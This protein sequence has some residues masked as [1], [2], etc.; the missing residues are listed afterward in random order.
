M[1]RQRAGLVA[2]AMMTLLAQASPAKTPDTWDNLH[3]VKSEKLDAVYLSDGADFRP[4]AKVILDPTHVAFRKNWLRD[5]N[6]SV[7]PGG[8][9]ISDDEAQA[10]LDD[11]RAGF[12][13]IFLKAFTDAGYQ[14][15]TMPGPDVLSVGAAVIDISIAAPDTMTA[16]RSRTF[17][18]E[19]GRAALVLEVRDSSSGAILARAVDKTVVGNGSMMMSRNSVSNRSDAEKLF[20]KWSAT[21]VAGL[22][23]LKAMSP[24]AISTAP[25]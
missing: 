5:Y 17:S 4:Y 20:Q 18:E 9:R 12:D 19:A 10:M 14:I 25:P 24:V 13:G 21:A 2:L 15:A 16:G 23:T 22:A 11:I 1:Y 7:R 3:L 8:N 6:S